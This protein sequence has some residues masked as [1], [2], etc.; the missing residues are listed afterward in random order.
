MR[1][2]PIRTRIFMEGEDLLDF[3]VAHV[4]Q[5]P[6]ESVIAVTSK[7]VALAEGRTV[8]TSADKDTLIQ[9]ESEYALKTSLVWLTIKDGSVLANA[10]VDESNAQGVY[11]LLPEDSFASAENIRTSLMRH[12]GVS[13]LGVLITDSRTAPLRSGVTAVGLGWAGFKGVRDYVGTRDLF[14][15][16]FRYERV[17]VADSLA[18]VAAFMMGEGAESQPLALITDA[19]VIFMSDRADPAEVRIAPED[20]LYRP[21]FENLKK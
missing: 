7:I 16:T 1:V 17:N 8:P 4:P 9:S 20:D 3:I 5:I 2:D 6:E 14:G 13:A 10:G 12:Y 19:P 15:R 18:T 11:I 21:F